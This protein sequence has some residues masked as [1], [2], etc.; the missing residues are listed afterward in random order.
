MWKTSWPWVYYKTG[1]LYITD[2]NSGLLSVGSNGG[3]ATQLVSGIDDF[4]RDINLILQSGDTRGRFFKY[5][6]RTKQVTLL[7]SELSGPA[8]VA[9]SLDGSYVL[10]TKI[11]AST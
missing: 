9:L 8:G 10:I 3:L 6:I 11:I 2:I 7:L 4:D 5:N 1:D